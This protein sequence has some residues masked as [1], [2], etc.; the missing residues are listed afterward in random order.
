[1]TPVQSQVMLGERSVRT[2]GLEDVGPGVGMVTVISVK[3]FVTEKIARVQGSCRMT[4]K[5]EVAVLLSTTA[6]KE[7]L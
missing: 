1:M 5:L 2:L 6:V 4:V 3:G 7:Q